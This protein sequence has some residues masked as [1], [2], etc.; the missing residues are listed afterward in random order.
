MKAET[1]SVTAVC[2]L[3]RLEIRTS[4]THPGGSP[5][6]TRLHQLLHV[7][8]PLGHRRVP[9]SRARVAHGQ[10]PDDTRLT[11]RGVCIQIWDL[12]DPAR[13]A[14]EV[15]TPAPGAPSLSWT[16]MS[17]PTMSP[18]PD[19]FVVYEA[20]SSVQIRDGYWRACG[21]IRF[22]WL[23]D[24]EGNHVL[25]GK[26][27]CYAFLLTTSRLRNFRSLLTI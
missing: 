25:S 23:Q 10:P 22:A 4:G 18:L 5:S 8:P 11:A 17:V 26:R 12:E 21:G 7:C 27:I 2:L 19:G 20:H 13:P 24:S 6:A 9:R 3:G 1:V 14:P 16:R 15:K